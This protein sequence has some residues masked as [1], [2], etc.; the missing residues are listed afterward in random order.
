MKL[1]KVFFNSLQ[2]LF[3]FFLRKSNFRTVDIQ[4]SLWHQMPEHKTGNTF[5]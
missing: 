2:K 5:D 4:I 3:L 1:G